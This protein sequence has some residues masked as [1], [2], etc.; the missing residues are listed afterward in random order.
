MKFAHFADCHIGSWREE[1][2]KALSDQAFS[3]V[4]E[5]SILEK[6]EFVVISGDLFNTA[7]PSIDAITHVVRG[8]R[9]LK[10]EGIRVYIIAGSHDFS[11]SG[12]TM[13]S[14]L[15]QAGLCIN[16]CKGEVK[17]GKLYLQFTEDKS[18]VKLTGMLGRRGMLEKEYYENIAREHLENEP[19]EKIFLFH[20]AIEELKMKE[21]LQSAPL[22]LLPKGFSYYAGGH[23]HIVHEANL[24]GYAN[25]VYP[26]PVFPNSFSELEE[27]KQGGMVIFD[28]AIKHIPIK[29]KEVLSII[30]DC[31]GKKIED[32]EKE[33]RNVEGIND[34]LVLIRL[35]GKLEG[36]TTD[37][38]FKVLT[39]E[40]YGKGAYFVMRNTN[41]VK[42]NQFEEIAVKQ[43]SVDELENS[44]IKEHAG[45]HPGLNASVEKE[46]D[47]IKNIMQT[48]S[49]EKHEG[50]TVKDFED[51][52]KKNTQSVIDLL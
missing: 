12:K 48:L 22:S 17:E 18:G 44:L 49:V 19:G 43:S 41:G 50:E 15:E 31:S 7:L 14:V 24:E 35:H 1:K 42:T 51:R 38:N 4:I 37:I 27:L 32:I 30:I 34:K 29:I 20:T 46:I 40:L 47:F 33:I 6:V 25:I 28:G 36:K 45:M 5:E 11:P 10:N 3:R 23:V 52:I 2:L 13:L 16:V 9:K 8:L 39:E 21:H 26:G